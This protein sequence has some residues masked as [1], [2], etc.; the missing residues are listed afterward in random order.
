M[1]RHI[2]FPTSILSIFD[3][4]FPRNSPLPLLRRLWEYCRIFFTFCALRLMGY[5]CSCL[6]FLAC[7][8][9]LI[10]ANGSNACFWNTKTLC[11]FLARLEVLLFYLWNA[12]VQ[13]IT[14]DICCIH[15]CTLLD[16]YLHLTT[17]CISGTTGKQFHCDRFS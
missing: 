1:L 9:T 17:L 6:L 16:Q 12:T 8:S 13:C 7:I 2:G 11:V 4:T 3:F 14:L 5:Q 10:V 15:L